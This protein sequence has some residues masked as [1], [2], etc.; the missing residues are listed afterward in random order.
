MVVGCA[1]CASFCSVLSL[2]LCIHTSPRL[3]VGNEL[4][5]LFGEFIVTIAGIRG[6]DVDSFMIG[7]VLCVK[8]TEFVW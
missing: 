2:R 4:S 7:S 5:G 8:Q 3:I 1:S 6:W